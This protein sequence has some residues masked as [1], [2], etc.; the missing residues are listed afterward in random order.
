MVNI[1]YRYIISCFQ[2]E[3]FNFPDL[4]S[5]INDEDNIVLRNC[6]W[7]TNGKMQVKIA[8][9]QYD[10]KRIYATSFYN[11]MIMFSV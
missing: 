11:F 5:I 4:D 3:Q 6:I 1:P 8:Q 10:L 2:L 9:L 7:A